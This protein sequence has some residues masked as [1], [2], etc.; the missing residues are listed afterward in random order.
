MISVCEK[1]ARHENEEKRVIRSIIT[2]KDRHSNT[3]PLFYYYYFCL[4]HTSS[5]QAIDCE[6]LIISVT[7]IAIPAKAKPARKKSIS[8]ATHCTLLSSS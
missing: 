8:S 5:L 3:T 6:I 4:Q 7:A 2:L 1:R